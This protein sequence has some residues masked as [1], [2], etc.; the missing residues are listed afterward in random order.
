MRSVECVDC[1][2]SCHQAF[3]MRRAIVIGVILA[4]NTSGSELWAAGPL[5]GSGQFVAGAGSISTAAG[6]VDITQSSAR[7]VIDW[8]SFSI[9][10]G[11]SVDV[12]NGTGATLSRVT[13]AQAATIDGKL[14]A[15]GSFYLIDPHGVVIGSKGVVTTGGRFVASTL[16]TSN[17]AFMAGG[18]LTLAGN[19]N[20]S[21]INLGK[22]SS[23]G[24][25]V[26][27]VSVAHTGNAGSIDA[28]KGSA[29]LATGAQVLL[30]D[31]SSTMQVFVQPGASGSVV[32]QGA[33]RAAQIQLA[34]ADGN[35]YAYAG[36]HAV[37]RATG[38][39]T[40]DG[41]VWL[42][43]PH[44]DIQQHE[45]ILA[46]NRDGSGG[47]VDTDGATMQLDDSIVRAGQWNIGIGTLN[48]GPHN[49]QAIAQSLSDGTS[50]TV[51]ATGD[52]N[53]VSTLRWN[54]NASLTLNAARDVTLG[55][56]TTIS[57]AGGG[58]LLLRADAGALDNAGS[59]SNRG[60]IDWSKST[61]IVSALYDMNGTYT[62][63][64]IR[65]RSGWSAASFSGLKTQVTAYRLVDSLADLQAIS[66]NL[67]GNYALGRDLTN[68]ANTT[69][70]PIGKG[71]ASGFTGQFDGFGHTLDGFAWLD[72]DYG[73]SESPVGLF[74]TI[75]AAGV[76]RNL[77]VTNASLTGT[78]LAG[79]IVAGKSAGLIANVDVSGSISDDIIAGPPMG[80]IVGDNTGT[81]SRGMANLAIFSQGPQ[82]GIAG[83]N[84]GTI[85]QSAANGEFS[86]G[87]HAHAGGIASVNDGL[88]TQS[89]AT[90]TAGAVENGGIAATNGGTISQSFATVAFT[91]PL[92]PTGSGGIAGYN[93][94]T[95]ASDVFWDAQTSGT[96]VGAYT[97]T[98]MPSANGLTTAQ[99]GMAS[100]FPAS[101]NFAPGGTWTFVSGV[102]HPVLQWQV[103]K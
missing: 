23:T 39:A 33:I 46:T 74:S 84:E 98:P 16:D 72:A 51:N 48:A 24:G 28:P 75:G 13:G 71:S 45:R 81:V 18:A 25:D 32:N 70:T 92:G 3:M 19:S 90:G 62:P 50:V 101:W 30:K 11:N 9:G 73:A 87:S 78:F 64:T 12:N 10:A 38:T 83:T 96:S 97:G 2:A 54:G 66:Q 15:T 8:K 57:N 40:R 42:V 63:G 49:A 85:V 79:G 21:V 44:G 20:A 27:L 89:Y 94:G 60:T 6:H 47:T 68:P 41:H 34:A 36:N 31:S 95:I 35:V 93:A 52:I 4:L 1:A 100:S 80:G 43:A 102:Q 99:M 29:E 14:N 22:I 58:N 55:P 26:F 77:D 76:V 53:M 69:L 59:V 86:E 88:I 5:P 82:G 37:L 91:P 56:V 65:S 103:A 7:G 61:G 17:A 67:G